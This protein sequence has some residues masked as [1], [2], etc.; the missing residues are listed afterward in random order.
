MVIFPLNFTRWHL[1]YCNKDFLPT[2]RGFDSFYGFYNGA[3]SYSSHEAPVNMG[4][5]NYNYIYD[6][7][8]NEQVDLEANGTHSGVRRTVNLWHLHLSRRRKK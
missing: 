7:V 8:D 1:G 3:S 4:R 5:H 6:F 2:R